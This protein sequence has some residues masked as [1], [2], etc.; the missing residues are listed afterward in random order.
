MK[1]LAW[2]AGLAPYRD[3][4]EVLMQ[5][6]LDDLSVDETRAQFIGV[7]DGPELLAVVIYSDYREIDIEM[8]IASTTPRWAS[9]D[10]IRALFEY[11]FIQLRTDR[12]TAITSKN[13]RHTRRFLERLGF[14][15]EGTHRKA[16][17]GGRTA[18]TYGMLRDECKW[19]KEGIYNGQEKRGQRSAAA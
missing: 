7:V 17:R 13:N 1:R 11:P 6:E 8:S 16:L 3:Q 19:L 9:R 2:G 10:I 18:C 12:V 14:R 4:V 15:L 5:R